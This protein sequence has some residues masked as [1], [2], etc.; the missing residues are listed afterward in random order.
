MAN[1]LNPQ[2]RRGVIL[3]EIGREKLTIARDRWEGEH[4]DGNRLTNEELSE[5][6]KL[7]PNTLTK[8]FVH[9]RTVDRA[10]LGRCFSALG[11]VLTNADCQYQSSAP[12]P[13]QSSHYSPTLATTA[14]RLAESIDL[15]SIDRF[16]AVETTLF[17]EFRQLAEQKL[18]LDPQHEL[19]AV[20]WLA[21]DRICREVTKIA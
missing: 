13:V 19:L 10:S 1:E 14:A 18:N 20:Y 15:S 12:A 4:R 17:N 16:V 6:T 5:I 21:I 9:N 11:A 7:S 8:I 3:T 2:R